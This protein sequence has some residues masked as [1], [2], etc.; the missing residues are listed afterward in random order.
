MK[1]WMKEWR[2]TSIK[3]CG[4]SER[5]SKGMRRVRGNERKNG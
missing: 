4:K 2:K 5:V 1:E 3:E